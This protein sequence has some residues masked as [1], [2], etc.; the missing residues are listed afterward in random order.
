[1]LGNTDKQRAWPILPLA[2]T[3]NIEVTSNLIP[4]KLALSSKCS[5]HVTSMLALPR[6]GNAPQALCHRPFPS[7]ILPRYLYLRNLFA[8]VSQRTCGP[9]AELT[10]P[11]AM[12]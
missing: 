9:L 1:M 5:T 11:D 8:N 10:Y 6:R 12:V 7:I 4:E 3:G 2:P